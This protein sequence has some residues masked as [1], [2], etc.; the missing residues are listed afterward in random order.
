MLKDTLVIKGLISKRIHVQ[1]TFLMKG[2]YQRERY[3]FNETT[4]TKRKHVQDTL[5][6]EESYQVHF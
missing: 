6:M 4:H 5:L 1:D 2:S 3:T